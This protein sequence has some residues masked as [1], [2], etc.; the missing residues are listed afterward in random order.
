M[1][2]LIREI[3]SKLHGRR[4]ECG[5][6]WRR[7]W[8]SRGV[9]NRVIIPRTLD[10]SRLRKPSRMDSDRRQNRFKKHQEGKVQDWVEIDG[11]FHIKYKTRFLEHSD[12]IEA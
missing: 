8:N 2:I 3:V 11:F 7:H 1:I 6:S 5:Q 9:H 4:S 12:S 10:N